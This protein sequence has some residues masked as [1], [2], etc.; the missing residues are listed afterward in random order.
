MTEQTAPGNTNN[1]PP[2]KGSKGPTRTISKPKYTGPKP[3]V[4][5]S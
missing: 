3:P 5:K 1:P 4:Y 2:S